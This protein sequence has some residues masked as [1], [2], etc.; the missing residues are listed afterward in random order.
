[1]TGSACWRRRTRRVPPA[2]EQ[3]LEYR[4][5][6]KDGSWR[7]L[8]S[9]ASAIRN[10]KGETE[11]LVIVNRDISER[12]RAEEL[13]AHNAFHDGLTNLPN[14]ALFLDRLQRALVLSKRHTDYKFAVLFID[15]DEF[16]VFNDSL[17][18]K[19]GDEVLIQI[20]HAA[21]CVA[22]RSGHDRASAAGSIK[23]RHAGPAR[24]R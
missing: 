5:R 14:R 22:A 23:G 4:I 2:R 20:G 3:R 8:E 10:A 15:I 16:K 9:T 17:G 12:K 1:M 7:I 6:H 18:H 13:L 19:V 21:D 11:K 24:R